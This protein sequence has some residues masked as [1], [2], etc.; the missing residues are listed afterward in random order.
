MSVVFTVVFVCTLPCLPPLSYG[1]LG[2]TLACYAPSAPLPLP[3]LAE[4]SAMADPRCLWRQHGAVTPSGGSHSS[5]LKEQ[6]RGGIAMHPMVQS[7]GYPG[8]GTPPSGPLAHHLSSSSLDGK[9]SGVEYKPGEMAAVQDAMGLSPARATLTLTPTPTPTLTPHSHSHP[10]SLSQPH[11]FNP[12]SGYP[13][14]H[15]SGSYPEP[16]GFMS[17][18]IQTPYL[19]FGR[20]QSYPTVAQTPG[21]PVDQA[22]PLTRPSSLPSLSSSAQAGIVG[23]DHSLGPHFGRVTSSEGPLNWP[24]VPPSADPSAVAYWSK[25]YEGSKSVPDPQALASMGPSHAAPA[26]A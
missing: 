13:S 5:T 14:S 8:T 7:P 22:G 20:S 12:I 4:K 10:H 6:A 2:P 1:S 17:A 3:S 23:G 19:D 11:V 21:V 25:V 24:G 18:G 9:S 16:S 26:G 15:L